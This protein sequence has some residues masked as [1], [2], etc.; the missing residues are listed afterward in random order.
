MLGTIIKFIGGCI[1]EAAKNAVTDFDQT[2][3]R[4]YDRSFTR[5]DDAL[6]RDLKDNTFAK[7]VGI[8][9]ELRERGYS[10]EEIMR[11]AKK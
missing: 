3:S 5:S 11:N 10:D 6:F 1:K 4:E 9:K 2:S 7:R 8:I